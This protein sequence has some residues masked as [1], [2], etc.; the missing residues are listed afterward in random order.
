MEAARDGGAEGGADCA[1]VEEPEA[2]TVAADEKEGIGRCKELAG[3]GC[4][5]GV[6]IPLLGGLDV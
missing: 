6:S 3:Y 1:G 4:C 5:G 2:M